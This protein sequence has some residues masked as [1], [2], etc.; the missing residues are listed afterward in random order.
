MCIPTGA[1][2]P[3]L[4]AEGAREN[5]KTPECTFTPQAKE[6]V[7]GARKKSHKNSSKALTRTGLAICGNEKQ[8]M[9]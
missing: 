6:G 4:Y 7:C 8:L 5:L 1:G 9:D 3:G 2:A